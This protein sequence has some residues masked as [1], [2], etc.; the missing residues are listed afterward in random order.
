MSK[1]I[2]KESFELGEYSKLFPGKESQE[3]EED[4]KSEIN[5]NLMDVKLT[6]ND[7]KLLKESLKG[8]IRISK[9]PEGLSIF[10][11]SHIGVANFDNFSVVVKPKILMSP[12]NLFGMINHAYG[13]EWKKLPEFTPKTGANYLMDII[14]DGFVDQ[15]KKIIKRGLYKSYVVHQEETSFLRGKLLLKQQTQN[16]LKN[17]PIFTCEFD[18]LEYDNLENQI[19]LFCLHRCYKLTKIKNLKSEIRKLIFQFSTIISEKYISEIDFK[20]INYTRQN[21]H[22]TQS[23][24]LA[25][26]IVK[27]SGIADF[28]SGRKH[29]VSSFFFDMNEIF[30]KFVAKLFDEIFNEEFNVKIQ[31]Q[32]R[33]W[34]IDDKKKK[35][36]RTDIL[37]ERKKNKEQIV[38]DTKYKNKLQD[39]DLYQ[40]GFYIHEY[41]EKEKDNSEKDD[42]LKIKKIGYAILPTTQEI[43][44]GGHYE[45]IKSIKQEI[46]I[47]KSYVNIDQVVPLLDSQDTLDKIKLKKMIKDL[48]PGLF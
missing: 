11:N 18:E 46:T 16:F 36:I 40:I 31:M 48:V 44:D 24:E 28:Y 43:Q 5:S 13:L 14:I 21:I 2:E 23:M 15:C 10:S 27:S 38:I 1:Q 29:L 33:V 19:M 20:K 8:K 26:M 41:T 22:Y 35:S 37:L 32:D 47:V 34:N 6:E 25:E 42:G 45:N 30:E 3:L 4:G 12:E 9:Q 17:K 39:S 7:K